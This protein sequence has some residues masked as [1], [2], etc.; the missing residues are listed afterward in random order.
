MLLRKVQSKRRELFEEP[1]PITIA[2]RTS[3]GIDG[4]FLYLQ[5]FLSILL[6]MDAKSTEKSEL[7]HYCYD[8]YKNNT[9]ELRW[10]NKF[11]QEYRPDEA[12][13]W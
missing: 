11:E 4:S 1:L 10:V 13:R 3:T 8:E 12:L 2:E 6:Q 7:L 5:L 9:K